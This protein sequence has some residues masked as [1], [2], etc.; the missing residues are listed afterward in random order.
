MH[1]SCTGKDCGTLVSGG[2]EFKVV[3][4]S[5]FLR[6]EFILFGSRNFIFQIMS[7]HVYGNSLL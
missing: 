4:N 2:K 3:R 7:H 5:E 6:L 1:S